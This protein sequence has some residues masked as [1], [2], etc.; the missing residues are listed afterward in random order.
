[1]KKPLLIA[2]IAFAGIGGYFGYK[3]M[4][5]PCCADGAICEKAET[6][7]CKKAKAST[8]ALTNTDVSDTYGIGSVAANFTLK[9][10]QNDQMPSL[11]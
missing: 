3:A 10:A 4:S 5:G 2:L 9:N 11:D 8:V 7:E 6:G 1:M